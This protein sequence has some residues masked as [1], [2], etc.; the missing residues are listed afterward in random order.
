MLFTRLPDKKYL[1]GID[2]TDNFCQI[3]Y[4]NTR[5]LT[6]GMDPHTFQ[7]G[8]GREDFDIPAAAF[9][10]PSTG[11][12]VYGDEA[13]RLS[14][15]L[16]QEPLTHLLSFAA[17]EEE[18]AAQED[19]A[20]KGGAPRT[21]AKES[22]AHKY[23]Q[24][25]IG[26]LQYCMS[27]LSAEV[28][29][30]EIEAVTFTTTVMDR[31]TAA[32]LKRAADALFPGLLKI[33][34]EEHLKSFYHYVLM[35]D[36]EQRRQ[37]VLLVDG[38]SD[39]E[40]VLSILS[41]NKKTRPIVCFP[42]ER[43]VRIPAGAGAPGIARGSDRDR[44]DAAGAGAPGGDEEDAAGAGAPGTART[45]D[46]DDSGREWIPF[47]AADAE[48]K[49]RTLFAAVTE[50]M[51]DFEFS[52]AYLTG[53]ALA[54]GWMK[55]SL[56]LI[57]KGRR[58]FQGDTLY[59]R[60]AADSTMAACGLTAKADKFFYLSRD[61][62]RC[63]IGMECVKKGRSVYQA[64]LDAGAEWYDA[65]AQIDILLED[66]DEIVLLETSV[67]R[68]DKRELTV[69]LENMPQRPRATTRL[70]IRLRMISADRMLLE[71]EDMGFGEIFPSSGMKWEQ[72]IDIN[73]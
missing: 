59:S 72:E 36:E 71:A 60:G 8:S 65:A 33:A 14:A 51:R 35:Q 41:Y 39:E 63:N 48:V 44:T 54:G 13:L 42:T 21:R 27:L 12:W 67:D 15:E 68:G 22:T 16:G 55:D 20:A 34:Y 46:R 57:A 18:S 62:L 70:R 52:A 32:V 37:S 1:L 30:E 53:P 43:K 66:G 73:G 24:I 28:M 56:N 6:A 69:K 38:W 2:I 50:L 29:E 7:Y 17:Q 3:S 47:A 58:A 64:L 26:F 19:P 9:R 25:L 10:D 11:K 61:A 40:L 23:G 4:L 49:D 45:P 31:R 5:R